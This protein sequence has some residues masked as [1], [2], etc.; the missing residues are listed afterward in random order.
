MKNDLPTT[1]SDQI[2]AELGKIY[3]VFFEFSDTDTSPSRNTAEQ[4]NRGCHVNR[5]V[6]FIELP[7]VA[8][9]VVKPKT[10]NDGLRLK[11]EVFPFN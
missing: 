4:T 6:S 9:G 10:H 2:F 7:V 5:C 11:N 3:R 8:S 1:L